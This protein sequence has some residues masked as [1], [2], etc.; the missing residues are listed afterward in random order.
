MK[1]ILLILISFGSLSVLAETKAECIDRME[2]QLVELTSTQEV[3]EGLI[4]SLN[5]SHSI[6]GVKEE[7][8]KASRIAEIHS[9][10]KKD[11]WELDEDLRIGILTLASTYCQSISVYNK[12]LEKA[13]ELE[14]DLLDN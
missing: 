5:K 2:A 4:S 8:S 1:F 12:H 11:F 9:S 14:S 6:E 10:F 13:K 3:E 7:S